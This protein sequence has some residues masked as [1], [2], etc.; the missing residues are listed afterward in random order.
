MDTA[1]IHPA[2]LARFPQIAGKLPWLSLGNWPTPVTRLRRLGRRLDAPLWIKHDEGSGAL[3]GGNKV[4]K[5]EPLLGEAV[6]R[7]ARSVLTVGGIGSNHVLAV[8]IYAQALELPTRAVVIPQ[9]ITK[10]VRRNLELDL[11][12]GVELLPCPVK[13]LVPI[14]FHRARRRFGP[15]CYATG[16]GGSSPLGTL[17]FVAAALE[18]KQQI[19]RGVLPE[20]G[21]IF[22]ALGS[23][24]TTAGLALGCAMAGMKT[25]VVGVRVVEQL[26]CNGPLTRLLMRRT[27]GLLRRLA[28]P[29]ARPRELQLA[30]AHRQFGGR[31]GRPTEAARAAIQLLRDS[32]GLKLEPTYTGKALAAMLEY[33]KGPGKGRRVLFWNTYNGQD[34]APLL[35]RGP[36]TELPARVRRWLQTEE[37]GSSST[38]APKPGRKGEP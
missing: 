37:G 6:E 21:D 13:E 29:L 8:A 3:Y 12:L 7:A 20:P 4:R 34:T 15:A 25:R 9:P 27:L 18:L 22:V 28:G 31:Y 17:G 5:L 24:G 26:I 35:Q 1:A 38:R 30:V 14:Y 10:H 11:A 19:D 16:P 36:Q 23:G 2:L 33:C 32:E